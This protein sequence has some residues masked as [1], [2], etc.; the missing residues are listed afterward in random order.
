MNF[1]LYRDWFQLS[2]NSKELFS[3]AEK[4]NVFL[5]CEW[6]KAMTPH[7]VNNEQKLLLACVVEGDSVLA[8][9]PILAKENKE[10]ASFTHPY[11][12][13]FSILLADQQ[14]SE[15]VNCLCKGLKEL[16]FEY[17]TLEPIS[18]EDEKLNKL[19]EAMETFGLRVY[20]NHKAHN[21]FLQVENNQNF[22]EYMAERPSK[23]RNTVLRKQRKLK[24]AYD[25]QIQL[26]TNNHIENALNKYHEIYSVS[27]KAN[28]QYED[29]VK[30]VVKQFAN[31]AW[32]RLAILTVEDKPI[33]AQL[34]FVTEGKASIFRL[35]Y[36][37]TWKD[38]SPGSIL[39]AYLLE[40]V[41]DKDKVKEIDFLSGNDAYKKDWMSH[42]RERQTLVFVKNISE[43][44]KP[45]PHVFKRL[46]NLLFKQ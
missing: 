14:Q 40:H 18:S 27:W 37:E 38:Y 11:S 4:E 3:L 8:I 33:A 36:D 7:L 28:E 22:A 16:E 21:W 13:L 9:L 6:F 32:P 12:S 34:W 1:I 31:R 10:W 45:S 5:S 17:L 39:M 24:R 2:K 23:V 20:R 42:R 25:Y 41:I 29:L 44:N 35:V 19:Q 30:D 43:E 46:S 15:I 26:F